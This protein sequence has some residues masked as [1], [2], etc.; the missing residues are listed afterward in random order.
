VQGN[1]IVN[2]YG[3]PTRLRGMSFFWSQWQGHYWTADTVRWLRDDWHVSVVRAAMGVE[4]GGYLANPSVEKAKVEAIVDSAIDVGIYVIIDWHDHHADE[5]SAEAD[6][7]FA[8]M[9]QK[10]GH[11]PNVLFEPFNEPIGQ[12]W[13]GLIKPYHEK[14]VST[15]RLHT[16]NIIVLGTP[17]YSQ[18]VDE[19]SL[20]PVSGVNLAYTIHFYAAAAGHR[21]QLR[22]RVATALSNGI[23]LF[24]TEWGTCQETGNGNLDL[25]DAQ[26]W[27]D[28]FA[29]HH[30]SDANWAVSDKDESCSALRP[31][32]AT[33]SWTSADLTTSGMW[34]RSSIRADANA[35]PETTRTGTTTIVAQT[36]S[37][38]SSN[39]MT[40]SCCTD[41]SMSCYEK[42]QWWGSCKASCIQG[43]DPNEAVEFQ[44]PWTCAVLQQQ[45]C[46]EAYGS[47]MTTRCC[48]DPSLSCY[49]KDQWWGTCK[50][51]CIQG[52]DP[53]DP[54][55]FQT[56]WTC[57]VLG[58][59]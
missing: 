52:V 30:I 51:S 33:S 45:T 37:D 17:F 1:T 43:V 31:G 58:Q 11:F 2:Q 48:T 14:I 4:L 5:H 55:E 23:A 27:L 18:Y 35:G 53:N 36:C 26:T 59:R 47:C 39:C 57:S 13:Q 19:A 6:V 9:A 38:A 8:E 25:V 28:L 15:I 50:D 46:S 10:Y 16:N 20:N 49:E 40:T 24:A 44:T 54:V 12:S 29:A 56:P 21:A 22:S 42:N 7:F 32:A 34:V 3:E 41:P